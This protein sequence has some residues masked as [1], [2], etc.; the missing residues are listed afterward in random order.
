MTPR[1]R[2]S[3][4]LLAGVAVNGLVLIAWTQGW[5][6]V[7]LVADENGG[8]VIGVGG[9]IAAAGLSALGLAGLALVGALSIAGP[10]FRIVLGVLQVLIGGTV[11]L[12]TWLAITDPV[13]SSALAVTNVTGVSGAESVAGL[14]LG[15]STTFWPWF[16][17]VLGVAAVALGITIVATGR[18]WPGSSRKYQ[19]VAFTNADGSTIA[20]STT[21]EPDA[22]A[23]WDS[24][25]D[26]SDPTSR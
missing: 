14:V 10:V 18:S 4:T 19:A 20:G 22:V 26:G 13:A 6:T 3:M 9:D 24:L 17:L 16:A 12:S 11:A 2:K 7:T 8:A 25:S 15:T 5:L 21:V 1:R 23:D